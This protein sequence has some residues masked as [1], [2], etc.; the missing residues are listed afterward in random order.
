MFLDDD[1]TVEELDAS[2]CILVGIA[3]SGGSRSLLLG[4][5][6]RGVGT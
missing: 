3:S 5:T 2:S 6:R 4:F 1:G